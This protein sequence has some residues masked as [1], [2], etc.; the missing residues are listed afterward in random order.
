MATITKL[1][2]KRGLSFRVRLRRKGVVESRTFKIRSDAERWARKTECEVD[3]DQYWSKSDNDRKTLGE[4]IEKYCTD[5]ASKKAWPE[6]EQARGKRLQKHPMSAKPILKIDDA[7][8]SLYVK[9]R[10]DAGKKNSTIRLE[11]ALLSQVFEEARRFWKLKQLKNPLLLIKRPAAPPGIKRR[12]KDGEVD[13]LCKH[14][15]EDV[16]S[17][18]R[19][20]IQ[21]ALRRSELCSVIWKDI[22]LE[23]GWLHNIKGKNGEI[24]SIP[25]TQEAVRLFSSLP[26]G[27]EDERVFCRTPSY[28][29]QAVYKACKRANLQG[30]HFHI[31]RHEATSRLFEHGLRIEQVMAVTRHR[32]HAMALRYNVSKKD[33]VK[34]AL[35]RPSDLSKGATR[36]Q[37][38]K[39]IG[40]AD[41]GNQER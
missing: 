12:F 28:V 35:D 16:A 29:T 32:T 15:P 26:R 20:G 39:E 31:T 1:Q 34:E 2:G 36:T 3:T 38:K 22:D 41:F 21:T 11:L 27:K 9:E 4:S 33:H 30:I 23:G 40:D 24:E 6:V 8:I 19:I 13:T 7:D 25:L 17:M 5:Y 10:S 18:V 14:L 37:K